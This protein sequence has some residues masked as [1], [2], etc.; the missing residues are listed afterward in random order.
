M[1]SIGIL[2]VLFALTTINV[3]RLPSATAQTSGY[4]VLISDVRSQ[5]TK[6]MARGTAFGI[7]FEGTSYII[8]TGTSFNPSDANNFTVELDPNLSFTG[9]TFPANSSGTYVVFTAG[10]GDFTNYVAGADSISMTNNAT[11]EVKVVRINKYGA[12]Y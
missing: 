4:D 5:Q 9:S 8:F 10:S 2:L 6:A 7:E 3:S 1:V 11:G 12:T